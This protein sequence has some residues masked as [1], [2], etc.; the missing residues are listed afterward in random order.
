MRSPQTIVTKS[1]SQ[2]TLKVV[3]RPP[4]EFSELDRRRF[5]FDNG[6]DGSA[7]VGQKRSQ[8]QPPGRQ[9]LSKRSDLCMVSNELLAYLSGMAE[10]ILRFVK[11]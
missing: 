9:F 7:L 6:F 11:T 1:I 4:S 3:G 5:Q 10:H 2:L 8:A